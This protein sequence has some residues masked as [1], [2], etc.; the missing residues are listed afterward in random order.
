MAE[1]IAD[2][3]M[4]EESSSKVPESVSSQEPETAVSPVAATLGPSLP[5]ILQRAKLDV[6][7]SLRPRSAFYSRQSAIGECSDC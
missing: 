1:K 6:G 4:L 5:G 7:W 3:Q 2:L